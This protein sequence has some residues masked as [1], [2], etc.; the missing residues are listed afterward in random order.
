MKMFTTVVVLFSAV[1]T[2]ANAQT[3]VSLEQAWSQCLKVTDKAEGPKTDENDAAR[4]AAFKACMTNMG[5]AEG[6]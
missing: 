2:A 4:V 1:A 6:K 5:H 3:K